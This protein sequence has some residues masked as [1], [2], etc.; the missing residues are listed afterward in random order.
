MILW[1]DKGFFKFF[2]KIWCFNFFKFLKLS[3]ILNIEE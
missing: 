2:N 1:F 3:K